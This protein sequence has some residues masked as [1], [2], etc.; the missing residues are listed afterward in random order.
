MSE[1]GSTIQEITVTES[2]AH[3]VSELIASEGNKALMLRVAV[4]A[5]G[6]SGFEYGFN[7]DED[8]N[9]DDKISYG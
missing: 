4:N 8:Q 3:R 1:I 5:G 6:C 9:D 7:L 2:A